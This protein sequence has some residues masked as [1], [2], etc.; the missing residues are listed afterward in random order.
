MKV[1]RYIFCLI[2]L[3]FTGCAHTAVWEKTGGNQQSFD[4]DSRECGFIAQQLSL[5]QSETGKRIDPTFYNKSYM[6][7]ITA[8]GWSPK[9]VAPEPQKESDAETVT[10]LA[11]LI[12]I[13][14]VSGFGQ[15]ITVPDTYRLVENK[16]FKSGPTIIE[17]F[18]WKGE[19]ASFINILFQ[20]NQAATFKTIPYPVSEPYVL[21]TSG[22]GDTAQEQLQWATFWGHIDSDWVMSTGAYYY[23]SKKER[24]IVAITKP[25]GQPSGESPQNVTLTRNQFMQ[26]EEF[27]SKWQ[28]WLN[29][30]FPEGPGLWKKIKQALHY[31]DLY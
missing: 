31:G 18:L 20:E 6:E 25:L 8:K 21:Y 12:S 5:Q 24:I 4:L 22:Q 13:N 14:N 23:A 17:Q 10:K 11:A 28:T 26:I 27:S 2:V 15:T 19:D 1:T 9:R 7:C 16:Q 30:Q 3:L 29:K